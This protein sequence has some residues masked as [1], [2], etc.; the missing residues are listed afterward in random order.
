MALLML[1]DL[2]TAI[3]AANGLNLVRRDGIRSEKHVAATASELSI[4]RTGVV[5][6]EQ[7]PSAV[8]L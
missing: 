5:K 4:G 3:F 2:P 6:G 1:V 8:H 7:A